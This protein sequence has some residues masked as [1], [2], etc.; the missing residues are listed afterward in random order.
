HKQLEAILFSVNQ[1][2]D[3]V[4]GT[5]VSRVE[6][7]LYLDTT[8]SG[9]PPRIQNLLLL[10]ESLLGVFVGAPDDTTRIDRVFEL[11][12]NDGS[13][14]WPGVEKAMA[15]NGNLA[16]LIRYKRSG[17]QKIEQL[18]LQLP[19]LSGVVFVVESQPGDYRIAG[20]VIDTELFIEGNIGPRLQTIARDQFALSVVRKDS[21]SLVYAT[22]QAGVDSL[23][24]EVVT[25]DFWI[26]PDYALG[27]APRGTSLNQIV[28]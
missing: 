25:K 20:F 17:F 3:D 12:D 2:S 8:T 7:D 26:F 27:I 10:N 24:A 4:L 23:Q 6:T 21:S 1:Y 9:N 16:S 19:G 28:R 13:E 22:E 14:I 18:N 15:V 5:W 11:P